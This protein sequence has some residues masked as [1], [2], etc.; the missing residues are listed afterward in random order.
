ML[1]SAAS[2]ASLN[3]QM[4]ELRSLALPI[5]WPAPTPT[6]WPLKLFGVLV[7]VFAIS[8]GAPFWFDALKRIMVIRSTVKPGSADNA[9]S[10]ETSQG[11]TTG[12][13]VTGGSRMASVRLIDV[14]QISAVHGSRSER[15]A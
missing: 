2:A 4:R 8:L 7:T 15:G 1:D 5:G 13:G 9:S 3:A 10:G 11:A 6:P 14:S 12:N